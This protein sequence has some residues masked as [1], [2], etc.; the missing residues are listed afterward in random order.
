[1][2]S[3]FPAHFHSLFLPLSSSLWTV[4]LCPSFSQ[5]LS[6]HAC[7]W[8]FTLKPDQVYAFKSEVTGLFLIIEL[9]SDI[10]NAN[11]FV[12]FVIDL[13]LLCVSLV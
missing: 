3:A 11:C 9:L 12:C 7:L 1:M 4:C 2:A 10:L 8:S 13:Y 5:P 6:V